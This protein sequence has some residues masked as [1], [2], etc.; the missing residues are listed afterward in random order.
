MLTADGCAARRARLWAS[1]PRPC[2]ALILTTSQSLAYF[3]GYVPSPFVFNTVE[4]AAAL[5]LLP[6]RSILI[7]DNLVETFLRNAFVDEIVCLH[8]YAA[9]KS[10]P[11]RQQLVAQALHQRTPQGAAGRLGIETMGP[12]PGVDDSPIILDPLI[13]G[14]RRCKDPDELALIRRSVA[15]GEAG[16]ASALSRA[17]PGM[18]ELEVFM[19]VQEAATRALGEPAWIY[20]DFVSGPRCETERGGP[21]SRRILKS[22]DL[23]LLDFS[24]VVA[25]YRGDF[26]NTFAIGAEPTA[27]QRELHARCL[28]ALQIGEAM[29][30]PGTEA[31]EIDAAVRRY[32]ARFD[33]E[34]F[35]PSHTGHGL[36]LG[37][38]EPPYLVPESTDTLIAGDVVALEPGLY[39]PGTAGM[40]LERN[41]LVTP[42]GH[43]RLTNHPLSLTP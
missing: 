39:V 8:W 13:R 40:R 41:Y 31:R 7:A 5:I 17:K 34:A 29:L 36:G 14:L 18:S 9:K 43:E 12:R 1:L 30:R 4:S 24:V 19:L 32:F 10:A 42:N 23:F 22:G 37:H 21:P 11:P 20:G 27:R 33:L 15:A 25:G 28:G 16:H 26:T 6:D 38:P 35:F 2:E 3:A